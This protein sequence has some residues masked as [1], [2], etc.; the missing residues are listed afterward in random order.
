MVSPFNPNLAPNLPPLGPRRIVYIEANRAPTATDTKY[1]AGTYYEPNTEWKD[2]STDPPEI[3]KLAKINSKTSATWFKITGPSGTVVTLSDTAGTK[4]SP[5]VTGNIQI[6]GTPGQIDVTADTVNNKLTLSLPGGGGAVDSFTVEAFTGPGTNPVIPTVLGN[7]TVSGLAVA[8]HSVPV[9]TR[10]RAANAFN[11]EVQYASGNA[12]TDATKSGLCHFN[13]T[14]FSVDANGFVALTGGGIAIDSINV[15]AASG[16]G[17]DPVVPDGAGQITVTGNQVATGTIG[18]NVIRTNSLAANTY[19]I[20]IQRSTEVSAA[21][22]T[23]NG[24]SHYDSDQFNVDSNAWVQIANFVEPTSW[25]PTINGSV[26][27]TIT[28]AIQAGRY[29]RIGP[30]VIASFE[31]TWTGIGT[32]SGDLIIS[33]FPV[34]FS[35]GLLNRNPLGTILVENLAFPANTEYLVLWGSGGTTDAYIYSVKDAGI[36]S[37]LQIAAN[38]TLHGTIAYFAT[39]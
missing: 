2:T 21:D 15:D 33:G 31:I 6:E 28:Y 1:R 12:T 7:V 10:S 17:T 27:G 38:G 18:A 25:T 9:E 5:D 26:S 39:I 32:A 37:F 23:K 24:V 29:A 19:T 14:Q 22:S 3:W 13:S 4:V 35:G 16:G 11:V 34:S 8:A 36:S 30:L 20:E